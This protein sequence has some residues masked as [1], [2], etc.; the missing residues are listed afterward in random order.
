MRLRFSIFTS[1]LSIIFLY[2]IRSLYI[3]CNL[4]YNM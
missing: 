3:I 2:D 4:M 1:D